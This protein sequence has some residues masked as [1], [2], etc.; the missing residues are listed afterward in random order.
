MI[1]NVEKLAPSKMSLFIFHI[2][3]IFGNDRGCMAAPLVGG[4]Q[5]YTITTKTRST[6]LHGEKKKCDRTKEV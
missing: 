1:H 2:K 5:L 4:H 6:S 3:K